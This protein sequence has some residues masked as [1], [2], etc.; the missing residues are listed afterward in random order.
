MKRWAWLQHKD[1]RMNNRRQL[2][3]PL[4]AGLGAL[5]LIRPVMSVTGIMDAIGRPLG[6]LLMTALISLAWLLVVVLARVRE[7]LLTLVCAGITYGVCSILLSTIVSPLLGGQLMGPITNPLAI[8]S[9]L[10]TNAIW[11]ALVGVCALAIRA[12]LRTNQ[13]HG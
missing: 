6:P 11:G 1:T 12:V 2:H 5:A 4:I 8:V 13:H 7:P 3:W 10:I 9:V